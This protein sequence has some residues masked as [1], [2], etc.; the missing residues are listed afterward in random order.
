MLGLSCHWARSLSCV[1]VKRRQVGYAEAHVRIRTNIHRKELTRWKSGALQIASKILKSCLFNP[2]IHIAT[3][4]IEVRMWQRE[5]ELLIQRN[6]IT[7]CVFFKVSRRSII[8]ESCSC[9]AS[10]SGAL[11]CNFSSRALI[12]MTFQVEMTHASMMSL[13]LLWLHGERSHL[14]VNERWNCSSQVY[15]ECDTWNEER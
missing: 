4:A 10:V 6:R 11:F 2:N 15:D 3:E 7:I 12:H 13:S 5:R 14:S 1:P 9:S 8:R